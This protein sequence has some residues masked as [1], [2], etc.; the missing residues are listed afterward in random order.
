MTSLQRNRKSLG[1]ISQWRSA[2]HFAR[3]PNRRQKPTPARSRGWLAQWTASLCVLTTDKVLQRE[4]TPR[5]LS[6][7]TEIIKNRS[8]T[9]QA[10]LTD[11]YK[12]LPGA[13]NKEARLSAIRKLATRIVGREAE[14]SAKGRFYPE[15]SREG[16]LWNNFYESIHRGTRMKMEGT[17]DGKSLKFR[18]NWPRS[19]KSNCIIS[20]SARNIF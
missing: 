3:S 15:K 19:F 5:T 4:I 18:K 9:G 1:S 6:E 20:K 12:R 13:Q 8:L 16:Y 7:A 10:E 2:L 11:I 17:F 14:M